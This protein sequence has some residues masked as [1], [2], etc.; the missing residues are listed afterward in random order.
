MDAT[1]STIL[2]NT[3]TLSQLKHRLNLLKTYLEQ[4][5][6]GG[7]P[8]VIDDWLK[9]LPSQFWQKFNK[10]N[11]SSEFASLEKQIS[12]LQTLTLYITFEPDTD[13]ITQLGQYARKTFFDLL[14]LDI[15]YDPQLIAGVALTWKGVYKDY[16]LRLKIEEKKEEILENFK[17]FLR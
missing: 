2:T 15:K 17:R 9:T 10:D 13:T 12:Q 7:T 4:Q 6:F 1:L 5:I 8:S 11:I 14:V 16:S 3:Y